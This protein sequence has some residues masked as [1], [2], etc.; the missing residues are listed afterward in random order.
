M[1]ST[2]VQ[3]KR[4]NQ[5]RE[6]SRKTLNLNQSQKNVKIEVVEPRRSSMPWKC[7]K[8]GGKATTVVLL[9]EEMECSKEQENLGAVLPET[10]T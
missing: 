6:S 4:R 2:H 7:T 8:W 10:G 3:W 1:L 9:D 5:R